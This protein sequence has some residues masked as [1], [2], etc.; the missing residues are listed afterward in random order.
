M[1]TATAEATSPSVGLMEPKN[2]I[3]AQAMSRLTRK[4]IEA[5]L[6]DAKDEVGRKAILAGAVHAVAILLRERSGYGPDA[7]ASVWVAIAGEFFGVQR[8]VVAGQSESKGR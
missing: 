6:E 8:P 4:R 5:A 3:M 1:Q 2:Q 7:C